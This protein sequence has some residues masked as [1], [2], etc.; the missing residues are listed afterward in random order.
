M[1]N[2]LSA[3]YS[4]NA[5]GLFRFEKIQQLME[6]FGNISPD[7]PKVNRQFRDSDSPFGF[8]IRI[9]S[10]KISSSGLYPCDNSIES[11]DVSTL[12]QEWYRPV[13]VLRAARLAARFRL[14]AH[15]HSLGLILEQVSTLLRCRPLQ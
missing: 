15:S 8:S 12:V 2:R 9:S 1:A 3:G 5:K 11:A 10:S 14:S 6:T 7:D 4:K 13:S